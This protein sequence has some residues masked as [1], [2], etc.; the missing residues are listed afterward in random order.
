MDFPA[1]YSI[2]RLYKNQFVIST[3]FFAEID[4]QNYGGT[5][6]IELNLDDYLNLK[7]KTATKE[8]I[9]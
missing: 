6:E 8:I 2:I 3:N 9:G 7:D 1:K 5:L 4:N